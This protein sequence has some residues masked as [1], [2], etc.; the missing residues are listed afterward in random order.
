MRLFTLL[1]LAG[2]ISC[3]ES[4]V[5]K[6][7]SFSTEVST[8]TPVEKSGNIFSFQPCQ[9]DAN[10]HY[11]IY[12][13]TRFKNIEKFP[14]L[15]LFDPHGDPDFPLEKYKSLADEYDFILL[16]SKDSKNGNSAEQTANIIQSMLYQSIQIE[17]VDT[18]QIFV[19][20]FSG[21]ARVASMLA[22]SPSGVKGLVICGAGIPA[23]SWTGVPPHLVIGI[24][25]NRDMNLTEII[26][27]KTH[28]PRMMS[29][30]H[31]IRYSGDHAWPL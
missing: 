4:K 21:G 8:S 5:E 15:I 18:N 22:L 30:Y 27:F 16:A 3:S 6:E 9:L 19:G 28:D 14:I 2:L 24:A 20:G 12:Y 7:D 10:L 13:P 23:G 26:N 17:K 29:R 25:G 1:C 11:S 31:I